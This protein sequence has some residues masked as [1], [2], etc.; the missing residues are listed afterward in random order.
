MFRSVS[1]V[2]VVFYFYI[3]WTVADWICPVG[4]KFCFQ[5]INEPP[6]TWNETRAKCAQIGG[7]LPGASHLVWNTNN[8]ISRIAHIIHQ[9]YPAIWKNN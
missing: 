6:R 8:R 2:Y 5:R 4:N 9:R 3:S 1:L 7:D